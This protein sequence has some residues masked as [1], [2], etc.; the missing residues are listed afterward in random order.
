MQGRLDH[1][2]A[3]DTWLECFPAYTVTHVAGTVSD[4]L[5]LLVSLKSRQGNHRTKRVVRR[6]EE[7][8][9]MVPACEEVIWTTW[10]QTVTGGS[11][12]FEL[13][14]KITRCRLAL[15]DWSRGE[16]GVHD[17]QLHHKLETIEALTVD[18]NMGQ[19]NQQIRAVKDEVNLLLFQDEIY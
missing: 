8:W 11:P 1:A 5:A 10:Q 16:F 18:N 3:I 17:Q 12:I 14:Q 7:K 2:L 9:A 15:C 19:H 6:F 13:S 4:H